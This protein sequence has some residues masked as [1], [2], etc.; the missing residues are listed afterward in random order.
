MMMRTMR[1]MTNVISSPLLL[2]SAGDG[3]DDE[4]YDDALMRIDVAANGGGRRRVC[5]L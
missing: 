5:E 1:N 2:D 3:G 4:D